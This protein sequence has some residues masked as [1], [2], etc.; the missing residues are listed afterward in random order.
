[1]DK[2]FKMRVQTVL[3][4]G[5]LKLGRGKR[6]IQGSSKTTIKGNPHYCA[7][8]AVHASSNRR[9]WSAECQSGSP[10][11]IQALYELSKHAKRFSNRMYDSST[12]RVIDYND[13]R[14][15]TY[16]QVATMFRKAIASLEA[17]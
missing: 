17:K 10:V 9:F 4:N 2:K 8:G 14:G 12:T 13:A 15:R 16:K 7:Y 6:W 1:M 11:E 3:K 5:L